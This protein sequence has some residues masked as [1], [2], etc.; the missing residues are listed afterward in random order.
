MKE[1]GKKLC[2][3]QLTLSNLGSL[4]LPPRDLSLFLQLLSIVLGAGSW[5]CICLNLIRLLRR[6]LERVEA[7]ATEA[8]R[9]ATKT[10]I[11]VHRS[12]GSAT[13]KGRH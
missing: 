1:L 4:K 12:L 7:R 13:T 8:A 10:L 2:H 9:L 5:C 6:M 3:L 11:L